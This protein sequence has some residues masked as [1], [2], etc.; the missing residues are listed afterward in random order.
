MVKKV[1][2]KTHDF[3][4]LINLIFIILQLM[5]VFFSL[6]LSETGEMVDGMPSPGAIALFFPFYFLLS[7]SQLSFLKTLFQTFL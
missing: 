5:N 7:M 3:R 2:H 4:G 1:R 6:A